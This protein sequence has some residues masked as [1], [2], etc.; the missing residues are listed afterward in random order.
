MQNLEKALEGLR[1]YGIDYSCNLE[2]R[3][4]YCKDF[5]PLHNLK[6]LRR[7]VPALPDAVV[8][9]KTT[10]EVSRTLEIANKYGIP[11]Y[12]FGGASGVVDSATPYE[13]GFALSTLRLNKIVIDK[14]NRVVT[15]GAGV[16]GGKLEQIL[17]SQNF[18]LRHIPQSLYC[19][20]VGG[21]VATASSGQYSTGYGNI[22]DLVVSLKVVLANGEILDEVKTPRR[23]GPDLKKIFIG[24]EGTL[25]VVTEATFK[26]FELP[27]EQIHLSFEYPT[28]HDALLDARKFITL[29]PVL[30][31]IFDIEESLRYFESEKFSLIMI[32]EGAG[33][34]E[35]A[36]EA[37]RISSGKEVEGY[38]QIWMNKRFDVS[39][40]SRIMPLGFIFDTI[41]IACF[42]K[43]AERIYDTVISGIRRISGTVMVS[44][45]ASHFYENGLCF[46]F[47]FVG[48]PDDPVYYYREVWRTA[49][50]TS[51]R[52]G[53]N[54]T[55]HHGIGRLR[56]HWLP[57]E[58]GGYYSLVKDLKVMLDRR[59]ILNRGVL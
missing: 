43:D 28:L 50:E 6:L 36:K 10:E 51:L 13:G 55:H 9:P 30:M 22:E 21:W 1:I 42:W 7:D 33:S 58:L 8:Y 16:I 4:A 35:K 14:E 59:N 15:A 37:R 54:I 32:F 41:E 56:K 25:G 19:S 17:N 27:S 3:I 53:G 57:R 48:L 40:I 49:M 34:S 20:T 2:D 47:T 46:Y 24:S 12:I 44:A 39:D 18:T 31:R 29:R 52:Y 26:I 5:N 45:H 23:A 11:V 38:T